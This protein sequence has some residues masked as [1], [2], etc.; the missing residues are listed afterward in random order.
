MTHTL[1]AGVLPLRMTCLTLASHEVSLNYIG[2]MNRLH[3]VISRG[4]GLEAR[5]DLGNFTNG[6]GKGVRPTPD[7]GLLCVLPP[8]HKRGSTAAIGL[9]KA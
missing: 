4:I 6:G 3:C 1:I 5:F 7:V 9:I 8:L 2:N